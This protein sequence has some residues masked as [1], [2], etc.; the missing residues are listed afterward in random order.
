MEL[1]VVEELDL[2]RLALHVPHV[3]DRCA[4][5][6]ELQRV[7]TLPARRPVVDLRMAGQ[8]VDEPP[9]HRS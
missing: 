5:Q 1:V 4:H 6:V 9:I 8:R 7:A 3:L 2:V